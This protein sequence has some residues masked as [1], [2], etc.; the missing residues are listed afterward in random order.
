VADTIGKCSLP[1]LNAN[2]CHYF[3]QNPSNSLLYNIIPNPNSI[4]PKRLDPPTAAV[5]I[6]PAVEAVSAPVVAV[7]DCFPVVPAPVPAAVVMV[8]LE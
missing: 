7:A 5:A 8:V 1:S 4:T 6:A 2:Q 3:N